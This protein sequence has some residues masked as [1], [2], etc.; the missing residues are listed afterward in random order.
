MI[1]NLDSVINITFML[2]SL[3]S[4]LINPLALL[5]IRLYLSEAS[6]ASLLV[7]NY[8]C[9]ILSSFNQPVM[10]VFFENNSAVINPI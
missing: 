9:I 2:H 7:L 10:F 6:Q 4:L 8:F 5:F 3:L 1:T